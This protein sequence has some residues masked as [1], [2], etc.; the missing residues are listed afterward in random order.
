MV[1]LVC[2]TIA[3]YSKNSITQEVRINLYQTT[4]GFGSFHLLFEIRQFIWNP[5]KYFLSIWNLFGKCTL[6]VIFRTY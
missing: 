5:K 3:S 6:E 4:I 1:F 2:F